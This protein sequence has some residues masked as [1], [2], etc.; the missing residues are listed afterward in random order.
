MNPSVQ[1]SFS[2]IAL[3]LRNQNVFLKLLK[4]LSSVPQ[5]REKK[6]CQSKYLNIFVGIFKI[7]FR[8]AELEWPA[9]P[10]PFQSRPSIDSKWCQS[11]SGLNLK[12]LNICRSPSDTPSSPTKKSYEING[13]SSMGVSRFN[14]IKWNFFWLWQE[15][16]R[17]KMSK[18]VS[19]CPSVRLSVRPSIQHKVVKK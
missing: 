17:C 6:V 15:L 11:K 19:A 5:K 2:I 13:S 1:I 3:P 9:N 8:K 10:P 16:K 7:Q 12:L 18:C 4:V 14:K